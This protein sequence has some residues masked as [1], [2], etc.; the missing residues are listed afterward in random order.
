M[1][2]LA[3]LFALAS[4]VEAPVAGPY[5][6]TAQIVE[7]ERANSVPA[8]APTF[9]PVGGAPLVARGIYT[10][11]DVIAVA[12]R[13]KDATTTSAAAP[14]V[15]FFDV[16]TKKLRA[17]SNVGLFEGMR[18]D[19]GLFV[20]STTTDA[21]VR[22]TFYL[23]AAGK[24]AR[25]FDQSCGPFFEKRAACR[26]WGVGRGWLE[27]YV[28]SRGTAVIPPRYWQTSR[29]S[30]GEAI[31][32]FYA[33]DAPDAEILLTII[34]TKGNPK[35][36]PAYKA[37]S[38][39]VE[40]RAYVEAADDPQHRGY[41]DRK[42]KLVV[43]LA[44]DESGDAFSAGAAVVR[45]PT[46][47]RVVNKDGKTLLHI[48][49]PFR[50]YGA[51]Q[52]GA[53]PRARLVGDLR[54]GSALVSLDGTVTEVPELWTAPPAWP[55]SLGKPATT[56]ARPRD[57]GYQSLEQATM[58]TPEADKCADAAASM[59]AISKGAD[60][61]AW[62]ATERC[63]K[64]GNDAQRAAD[65]HAAFLYVSGLDSGVKKSRDAWAKLGGRLSP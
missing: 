60:P 1:T 6:L 39:F 19:D 53:D 5:A 35:Y 49:L 25:T 3:L 47:E 52:G 32:S 10:Y 28:D 42:G 64:L 14:G 16:K 34:D 11:K 55:A 27:Y 13:D 44:A 61:A 43:L 56:P 45:G 36:R 20:L 41:I 26:Q 29:F 30:G 9:E 23:D 65:A 58:R 22:R 51:F 4:T 15:R 31:V 54:S 62:T 38:P 18:G 2:L 12:P 50:I 21:G 17:V 8:P 7:G 40:D 57:M 37:L 46:G 24:T 33:S 63:A 48:P 59:V